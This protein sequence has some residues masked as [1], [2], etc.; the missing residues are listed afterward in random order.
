MDEEDRRKY[1]RRV[2]SQS[3]TVGAR[4]PDSITVAGDEL[5]LNEFL[6]ETR[7]VDRIPPEAEA[8]ITEAKRV[9]KAER[10]SRF[11][12]LENDPIDEERAEQLVR[13]INGLDRALNALNRIRRPTYAQESRSSRVQDYKKWLGFIDTVRG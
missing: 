3:S 7:K 11:E 13:E 6:I 12:Q 5:D 4:I 10:R 8:K 1:I 2:S 9:L